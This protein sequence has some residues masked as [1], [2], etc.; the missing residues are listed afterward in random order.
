MNKKLKVLAVKTANFLGP[1]K[2]VTRLLVWRCS[3]EKINSFFKNFLSYQMKSLN[4]DS[5]GK[6]DKKP[7]S[8]RATET[9][10]K[11]K[12]KTAETRQKENQDLG[13]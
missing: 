13:I 3:R 7:L 1:V 6:P 8:M 2:Y 9:I 4:A 5:W 11:N 10:Q 12:S